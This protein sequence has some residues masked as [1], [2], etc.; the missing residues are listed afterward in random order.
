MAR[1]VNTLFDPVK[2]G[3]LFLFLAYGLVLAYVMPRL[4]AHSVKVIPITATVDW[5]VALQPS[6][7]NI[8]QS[9]Y[10]ALSVGVSLAFALAAIRPEF[11][12]HYLLALL[13]GGITLILTGLM[14]LVLTNAGLESLL[15]PFR[16]ATY[17]LHVDVKTSSGKRVV[18][19]MPEASAFGP[20]CVANAASLAF[21][22]PLFNG[23]IRDLIVPAAV[24]WGY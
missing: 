20:L 12:R 8:T 24:F 16:N 9:A 23:R 7:G 18:G 4:F 17:T 6:S 13:F 22:R 19:L 10:L 21:L 2:L 11:L 5:P 3:F 15:E 1:A 14:D